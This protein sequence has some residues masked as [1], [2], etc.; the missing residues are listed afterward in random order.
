MLEDRFVFKS[1]VDGGGKAAASL[2]TPWAGKFKG[3]GIS[4]RTGAAVSRGALCLLVWETWCQQGLAGQAGQRE[5][6]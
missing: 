6:F 3:L 5:G 1:E 2:C 4:G